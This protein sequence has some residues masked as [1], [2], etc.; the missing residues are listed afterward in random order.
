MNI[1]QDGLGH[2]PETISTTFK[3]L[4]SD[5]IIKNVFNETRRVELSLKEEDILLLSQSRKS[6]RGFSIDEGVEYADTTIGAVDSKVDHAEG[7][8]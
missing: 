6:E 3:G 2:L 8:T 7:A 4:F 5:E 1:F